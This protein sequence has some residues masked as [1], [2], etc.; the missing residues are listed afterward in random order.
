MYSP[1]TQLLNENFYLPTPCSDLPI[2]TYIL[3][4][5]PYIS[6]FESLL[7]DHTLDSTVSDHQ[8]LD[9][10]LR[11]SPFLARVP[12][13][14]ILSLLLS[15]M[16]N[17]DPPTTPKKNRPNIPI[18]SPRP[19]MSTASLLSRNDDPE[20]FLDISLPPGCE[21]IVRSVGGPDRKEDPVQVITAAVQTIA[22][23]NKEL[24]DIPVVVHP[25]P[26]RGAGWTSSC[27]IRLDPLFKP[28]S[29]TGA[30]AEPRCDLLQLWRDALRTLNTEWEVNWAPTV[31]GTDKRMW[32]RFPEVRD[33]QEN[34]ITKITAHL[35]KKF[36]SPV[37]SS[38]AMKTGGVI[39]S[40]ACHKHV[41]G[42][43]K[44]GRVDIPGVQHPL[45][46]QRGRQIEIENAFELA[47]MGLTDDI[48]GIETILECWLADT[49]IVDGESTLA[50]VRSSSDAS[51]ALIFHMT[52][53]EA[54]TKVLSATTAELF[55]HTFGRKYPSL[56][57][58]QSV[59]AI[60]HKGLWRNKTIRETFNKGSESMTENL[61]LLQQQINTLKTETRQGMQAMQME[62]STITSNLAS[63]TT[64]V[65]SLKNS[66]DST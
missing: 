30:D 19:A 28:R 65:S 12:F 11:I 18:F 52:T 3:N 54:A 64:V 63:V 9:S 2:N 29:L 36:K 31:R 55:H 5:T 47:I 61:K 43:M 15:T 24:A 62:M 57:A 42:I 13:C 48:D 53:W 66:V 16:T 26:L 17:T 21:L 14:V 35:E 27:Y 58:P 60:N 41:D 25:F 23:T 38:F 32:L 33:D 7:L 22:K 46:P 10:P 49:F 50:G 51:E 40:L 8:T 4:F 45:T 39:V 6:S 59:Y 37:C 1:P 20:T 44:L 56:V 34:M